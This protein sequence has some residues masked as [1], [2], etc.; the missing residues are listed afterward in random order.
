MIKRIFFHIAL[1]LSLI[2]ALSGQV[3]D[4]TT[5]QDFNRVRFFIN[6][7]IARMNLPSISVAVAREGEII[8]EESFGW[9]DREKSI[10]A[11]PHTIYGLASITKPMTATGLMLL[12]EKGLVD[13]NAPANTYLGEANLR[14]FEGSAEEATIKRLLLHTAGL[15]MYWNYFFEGGSYL[16]PDMDLTISRFGML[17]FPP[18]EAFIYSNLGYGIIEYIIE[19]ISKK[20]YPE[21][22]QTEVFEHLGLKETYIFNSPPQSDLI[23]KSYV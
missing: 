15:P 4:T 17:V 22:M 23:D 2:G 9:A 19:R 14:A 7:M 8:W 10:K 3:K 6:S 21:F 11:T 5:E 20:S 16:R 12:V 18:G 1:G 13:L